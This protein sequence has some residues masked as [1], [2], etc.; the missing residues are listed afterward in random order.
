MPDTALTPRQVVLQSRAIHPE[1]TP[2]D[3]RD[4]LMSEEGLSRGQA[5]RVVA[6]ALNVSR[7]CGEPINS[8]RICTKCNN[9]RSVVPAR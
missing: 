6:S 8:L 9:R 2:K 5:N 7:C 3:H 4:Y 1:W